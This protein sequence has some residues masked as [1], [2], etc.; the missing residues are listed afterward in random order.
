MI[1]SFLVG[2]VIVKVE[3]FK[4]YCLAYPESILSDL[5]VAF[6]KLVAKKADDLVRDIKV[7]TYVCHAKL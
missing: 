5:E 1:T 2:M 3:S 7:C 6:P 4:E